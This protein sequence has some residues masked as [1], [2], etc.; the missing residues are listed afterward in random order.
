MEKDDQGKEK[1]WMPAM[2][3]EELPQRDILLQQFYVV[4]MVIQTGHEH[5]SHITQQ[6]LED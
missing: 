3:G 5:Q 2:S 4:K 1:S 6:L